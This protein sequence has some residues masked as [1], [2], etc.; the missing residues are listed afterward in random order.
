M[1]NVATIDNLSQLFSS[2]S[3]SNIKKFTLVLDLDE[4]IVRSI[5]TTNIKK[6]NSL[7]TMNNLLLHCIE[8]EKHIFVFYRPHMLQFL[9][10]MSQYFNIC[11]FTNGTKYYAENVVTMINTITSHTYISRWYSRTGEYPFY[12]YLS[13]ID[14]VNISEVL[15]I[16]DNNEIWKDDY[17][18]VIKI[19][20][21][22]GP[23]DNDYI[24]DTELLDLSKLI[25]E[26]IKLKHNESIY[27][28]IDYLNTK[29]VYNTINQS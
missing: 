12:K 28:L 29:Y 1:N 16:D 2:V 20:Q 17:K 22:H 21:F 11:V 24:N 5:I 6:I 8:S 26:S 3:L 15:I 4:T 13:L 18:N 27:D 25:T 14:H 19:K 9:Q 7:K 23:D 10:E